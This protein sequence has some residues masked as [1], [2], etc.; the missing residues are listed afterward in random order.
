ML[1][2]GSTLCVCSFKCC[3]NLEEWQF[4]LKARLCSLYLLEKFLP[5]CPMY[6]LPQSGHVNLYTPIAENMLWLWVLGIKGIFNIVICAICCL[7]I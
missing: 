2:V 5:L 4:F 6:A 1:H 7:Y 3:A